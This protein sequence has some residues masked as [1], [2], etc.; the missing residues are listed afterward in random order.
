MSERKP[1]ESGPQPPFRGS[2]GAHEA[3]AKNL[4]FWGASLAGHRQRDL[5]PMRA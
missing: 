5:H 3:A 1:A 4:S 2:M